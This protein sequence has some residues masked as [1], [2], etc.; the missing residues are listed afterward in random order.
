MGSVRRPS[1]WSGAPAAVLT[2][3]VTS[4]MLAVVWVA[5]LPAIRD[6]LG[7]TPSEVGLAL[8]AT[9]L[10]SIAAITVV[11]RLAVSLGSDVVLRW[12]LPSMAASVILVGL[13]ASYPML[14]ATAAIAGVFLGCTDVTMNAQASVI[15][16]DTGRPVLA[17][18]HAGWSL[19][20]A[21]GA[22]VAALTAAVGTRVATTV[23]AAASMAVAAW[24]ATHRRYLA[25]ASP[26]PRR[27][28]A[29]TLGALPRLILVIGLVT[30]LA[31]LIEG[32]VVGWSTLYL[33][34]V[35]GIGA[36][37]AAAGYL[38]YELAMAVGRLVGD[39]LRRAWGDRKTAMVGATFGTAGLL[40]VLMARAPAPAVGGLVVLGIGQSVVVPIMFATAG[41]VSRELAAAGIARVGGFGAVGILIGPAAFG[42]VADT[43][44]MRAAFL[45]LAVLGAGMS[46]MVS[47]AVPRV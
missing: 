37:L 5:R 32:A 40:L 13:S 6:S 27:G 21:V 22:G 45:G 11:G 25:D 16:R 29:L 19:G 47:R 43:I 46:L 30:M 36:G 10:G 17:R 42:F 39:P 18:M 23:A 44:S 38:G 24:L 35:L 20:S 41:L 1:T 31:Y 9:A 2:A 15:E 12:S 3:F 7:L 34:D 26:D 14:L 28:R 33:H 8:L 4:G